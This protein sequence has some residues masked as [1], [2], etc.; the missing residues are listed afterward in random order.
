MGDYLIPASGLRSSSGPLLPGSFCARSQGPSRTAGDREAHLARHRLALDARLA[1]STEGI[2]GRSPHRV[3]FGER[4]RALFDPETLDT[5]P[6]IR[7]HTHRHV[8]SPLIL[9]PA[10]TASSTSFRL[11]LEPAHR[12]VVSSGGGRCFWGP[13]VPAAGRSTS[14]RR[15]SAR[16]SI[17]V[18]SRKAGE[19]TLRRTA[20]GIRRV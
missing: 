15:R 14:K 16:C 17:E 18:T 20:A 19:P 3:N 5:V 7:R 13:V 6:F 4:V 8:H 12:V 1:P 11:A 9:A 2:L 10:S